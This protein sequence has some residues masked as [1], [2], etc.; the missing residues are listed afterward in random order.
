MAKKHEIFMHFKEELNK[1]KNE[2]INF[3]EN[4]DYFYF[5][6]MSDYSKRYNQLLT[7]YYKSS[8]IP[9]EKFLINDFDKSSSGKTVRN[10]C[11]D[12]FLINIDSTK[13]LIN[14][15]INIE[16]NENTTK[17]IELHQMRKCLKIGV[18]GCP[19]NPKLDNQKVFIGMPFDNRYLDSYEYG[20]KIALD[21]SGL[22]PY[23]ADEKISNK[24]IMCKI[25]EQMQ[26]C[27]YLVFNISGLNPNVMLELGLSYGLGKETIIIKDKDT[28][29]ISDLANTEYI[30]YSHAGE[31]SKKLFEFFKK[32]N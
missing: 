25:C 18:E 11:V 26:I 20:I 2:V 6:R 23:R 32:N 15:K 7:K 13:T 8:G 30:E 9:L 22:K 31:L 14:E 24:D 27:K 10:S 19:K 21:S 4:N 17:S 5:N 3:N 1:L 28:K 29:T 16:K 12:R